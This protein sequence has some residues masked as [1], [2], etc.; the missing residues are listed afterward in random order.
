MTRKDLIQYRRDTT[1]NWNSVNPV[2]ADGEPAYDTVSGLL[3][4][5]DG[6]T[7]Y[8][9]LPGY[10]PSYTKRSS[11]AIIG[12]EWDTGSTDPTL[13]WIDINGNTVIPNETYWNTHPIFSQIVRVR[14]DAARNEVEVGNGKG[15]GITLTSNYIMSRFPRIYVKYGKYT[16]NDSTAVQ[17]DASGRYYR[18]WISPAPYDGFHLDYAYYQEGFVAPANYLYLGSFTAN[19]ESTVIGSKSGVASLVSTTM[20]TFY[21]KAQAIGTGWG[22]TDVYDWGLIQRLFYIRFGNLNS[23]YILAPGRTK[24][25]NTTAL[26]SGAAT[27]LLNVY[28]HG[29]GT[30]TQGMAVFGLENWWGNLWQHTIGLNVIGGGN[31]RIVKPDGTGALAEQLAAGSYLETSGFTPV[32]ASGS[33]PSAYLFADPVKGL[34]LPSN[35]SG[36]SST[37]HLCD[38]YWGANA[39]GTTYILLAGGDWGSTALA[40]VG[41]LVA[42][43]ALGAVSSAF[44]ARLRA[45]K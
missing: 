14:L 20:S 1:A 29:G 36:G 3:K 19:D 31:I 13:R 9:N 8:L 39:G 32:V 17:D 22:I 23:Q 15:D 33:Y 35:A 24:G 27:S 26:S 37:T 34:F 25:S 6:V 21:S 41:S 4:I 10:M 16:T 38:G 40:G 18:T 45:L 5:G 11:E 43:N 12:I 7:P 28:G 44:G 30:D 42:A 2:L